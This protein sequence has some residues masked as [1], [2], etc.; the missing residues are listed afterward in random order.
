[1]DLKQATPSELELLARRSY[2]DGLT[3]VGTY[4]VVSEM[5]RRLT[6]EGCRCLRVNEGGRVRIMRSAD[7]PF[8]AGMPN[9]G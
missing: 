3:S 9:V 5:H 2:L 6:Q 1:M 7:C 4:Q 8:H